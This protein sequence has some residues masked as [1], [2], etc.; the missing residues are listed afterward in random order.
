M[1]QEGQVF[2]IA[3]GGKKLEAACWGPAPDQAETIVL[4][5]EGLGSL[6]LWKDFPKALSE[7]TGMGVFAYSRAGYGNSDPCELPRGVDYMHHE[8]L[9]VLPEVLSGIGFERGILLGHSDG[10]SIG[11]V[12]AGGIQDHRVRGL[13]LIAPHFFVEPCTK[14]AADAARD[15]F[16][17]GDLK[18]R[19]ALYHRDVDMAFGGWNDAWTSAAFQSWDI[20]DYLAFIRVPVMGIQGLSDPYGTRAQV[21]VLPK[22]LYAPADVELLDGVGH[23]PHV[24]ARPQV[25]EL[26]RVFAARLSR[27]E[28]E[29]VEIPETA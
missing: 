29:V 3:A 27:I 4:L 17:N 14:S 22:E 18:K 12:Y 5:H 24:E 28:D 9:D 26:L 25:L 16:E 1:W 23:V 7:A 21:D 15:A 8:A 11:A 10:A 2:E 13:V 6:G 19:L 20:S